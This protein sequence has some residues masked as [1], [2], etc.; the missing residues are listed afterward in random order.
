MRGATRSGRRVR[1]VPAGDDAMDAARDHDP[2]TRAVTAAKTPEHDLRATD[3]HPTTPSGSDDGPSSAS[4]S[5]VGLLLRLARPTQWAKGVFVLVGPLYGW[6]DGREVSWGA[7]AL[8]FLVFGLCSS[9]GYVINDIRDR[10]ADRAHPRKRQRPIASG[11]VGVPMARRFAAG[12]YIGAGV[13]AA[14][15]LVSASPTEAWWLTLAAGGYVLNVSAYNAGLKHVAVADAMSLA[16]G[17]VLRVL[18]GCA[19]TGIEPSTWLLNCTLFLAMFLAFAKRLGE[20]QILGEAGANE[21]RGVQRVYTVAILRML[22]VLSA[23][24]TLVTYAG[25]VEAR[26][27]DYTRGFNLLWLSILPAT[28]GLLRC[29]VL[30]E[31]GAYDD[32]TE[33]ASSD[34]PFQLAT[35]GFGLVTLLV[36]LSMG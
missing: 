29:I 4:G 33:L 20:R 1:P 31:R 13:G 5:L 6:L 3:E 18:G 14:A 36:A 15:L 19:A 17:F 16:F 24:A 21:A 27:G 22:V 8:A 11:A 9:A 32:P 10:E 34:G 30:V 7:A 26:A 35:I 2:A 12:L 28:F 23:V 25:Y